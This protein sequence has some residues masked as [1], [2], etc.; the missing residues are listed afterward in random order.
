MKKFWLASAVI[1][2]LS[3]V[4]AIAQVYNGSISWQKPITEKISET[5]T[6]KQLQCEP[7]IYPAFAEAAPLTLVDFAGATAYE[8]LDYTAEV[9]PAAELAGLSYLNSLPTAFNLTQK[10]GWVR[11]QPQLTVELNTVRRNPTTGQLERLTSYRLRNT[12]RNLQSAATAPRATSRT[13][14]TNSVLANGDWYRIGIPQ[15][16][17]YRL[18]PE[19]L[20][21]MGINPAQIDPR[22]LQVYGIGGGMLPR[23]NAVHR[24][25]DL[26]EIPLWVSG[27]N[28][29]SFDAGDFAL[30]Y[31]EGP[32]RWRY[33]P[34]IQR[35][36]HETNLYADTNYY[37]IHIGNTPGKR[38]ADQLTPAPANRQSN[39]FDLLVHYE[40]DERNL[41]RSGSNWFGETFDLVTTRNFSF[42]LPNLL[43]PAQV[44]LY[45]Q[46]AARSLG[47]NSSFTVRANGSNVL[48]LPI[49]PTTTYYLDPYVLTSEGFTT[50]NL[51]SRSLS[52]DYVYNK[53]NTFSLGFLDYITLIGRADLTLNGFGNSLLFCDRNSIG[54]GAITE[55]TLGGLNNA[56]VWD[57]SD[58]V[59]I[60]RMQLTGN[61]FSCETDSLKFFI[62]F[63][64]TNF[65]APIVLGRIPNQNLHGIS[66]ADMVIVCHPNFI[67]QAQQLASYRASRDSLEVVV[68]TTEQCYNEWSAGRQDITAIRSFVKHLYDQA[69]PGQEPR[70]L[71]LFGDASY[72]FKNRIA[73]NTNLVPTFQSPESVRPLY[74]YASDAYYGLLDNNEGAFL[75]NG[76]DRMDI[77][78]GRFPV[79][80]SEQ[81][82][83]MIDKIKRYE[84]STSQGDWRNLIGFMADDEDGNQHLDDAEINVNLVQTRFPQAIIRKYYFDAYRQESRPGGQRYPELNRDVNLRINNGLLVL[85]Y[86]GHGG[87]NGMSEERLMT[88]PEVQAW[89]N[90]DRLMLL[91]TAT[92]EF[93]RFDD[94][95]FLS[96]GEWALLNPGGGAIAL[97]TTT[98]VTFTDGNSALTGNM[99]RDHLFVK[100]NGRYPTL[101]EVFMRSSNPLLGGVN[102]RNFSLLGDPSLRLAIPEGEAQLTH[103]NNIQV[104]ATPDTLKALAKVTISGQVND[105]NGN[106]LSSYNGLLYPTVLDKAATITT[107]GND[108]GSL[109]TNFSEYR[110]ILYRGAASVKNGLWS[111]TFIVPR[112]IAYNYGLG[113]VSLYAT[114][115]QYDAAGDFRNLIIGGTDTADITDNEGPVL[116][117]YMNDRN[118]V[119]GGLTNR[120][121]LFIAELSDSSGIN[122]VGNGIGR[123]ITLIRNNESN[124]PIVLNE[125][126]QAA[127]DDYM[128]GEINYPF[129]NLEPGN[130]HLQLKVWDVY[131]NASDGELDFVVAETTGLAIKNLLNYPN[132]FTTQTTFHF[133]H[134]RP[135]EPLEV[136]L[137]VYSISGKL[138][139]TIRHHVQTSGF[140]ADQL[141][142]DGLDDFGDRIGRGVYIYQLKIQTQSGERAI[143]TQK[144][145]ILR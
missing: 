121:P 96:A 124:R 13:A 34:S 91:V 72:D 115:Q 21:S 54:P 83:A 125:F 43:L 15:N 70:Y 117:L 92:C 84:A 73:G 144:L 67:N 51:N 69:A 87:V 19:L 134:N 23:A 107:L 77:A 17:I 142:W 74:S 37:Y 55:F 3:V 112:D 31:A 25:D 32:Q 4:S 137:Q 2:W 140:H 85:N 78:I 130:Y 113:R 22:Q 27:E 98:R 141:H 100:Q 9:V 48:S 118:F 75:E 1:G 14:A 110:N 95:G 64:G 36:I 63:N 105:G 46:V 88:I 7:C 119:N 47:V 59:R 30:F 8:L 5:S 71:L 66:R 11:K 90:I 57:V 101:G 56:Q 145:V 79:T 133:D 143:E 12:G 10:L 104:S 24:Y 138:V 20:S 131:N 129:E 76:N 111:F 62:A 80:T 127:V 16:G 28:D 81:A 99:Y 53:P 122:T 103:I 18:G 29:G 44:Q 45:T 61:S 38:I 126:Y 123:D 6:R 50:L 33:N 82:Q 109:V 128:R 35:F 93:A 120:K 89:S 52:L 68:V 39:S 26:Q 49:L 41:I 97:F 114:N 116:R 65:P 135:N 132:P 108:P 58:P 136:N 102:T 94:P 86:T 42:D 40:K 139:K 106:L 60:R